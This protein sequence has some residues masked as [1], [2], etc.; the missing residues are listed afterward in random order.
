[1]PKTGVGRRR[2][3]YVPHGCSPRPPLRSCPAGWI[4]GPDQPALDGMLGTVLKAY[5]EYRAG[6]GIDWLG[7][8]GPTSP[9]CCTT[10]TTPGTSTAAGVSAAAQ[11]TPSHVT[12]PGTTRSWARCG[13]AALRAAEEI[14]TSTRRRRTKPPS[15]RPARVRRG[16]V[17][18]RG[19]VARLL[20]GDNPDYPWGDG[21][22]GADRAVVGA[23]ARPRP[24]AARRARAR[25][26]RRGG[27][28]QPPPRVPGRLHTSVPVFA[29][30][31]MVWCAWP[32]GAGAGAGP[33]Q[34]LDVE[35]LGG[36]GGRALPARG[37][38]SRGAR[39]AG[40]RV[41]TLRRA[42][43]QP[44]QRDRVRRPLRS[45]A[46]P[47]VVEALQAWQGLPTTG[48]PAPT[49]SAAR[50]PPCRSWRAPVGACGSQQGAELVMACTGGQLDLHRLTGRRRRRGGQASIDGTAVDDA[51]RRAAQASIPRWHKAHRRA[52]T[53]V[54]E[55]G[56]YGLI[57]DT[58][59]ALEVGDADG[60]G[61]VGAD[62]HAVGAG[63]DGDGGGDGVGGGADHRHRA[64]AVS[65]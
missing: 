1:M 32:G 44:V 18:R 13:L 10:S 41:G 3:G 65:W 26:P 37:L 43:A 52:D 7:S 9:A 60:V 46:Q 55:L 63:A 31:T 54:G 59:L 47:L 35:P 53:D 48:R 34:I 38:P 39:R 19:C 40:R 22:L 30:V 49:P 17:H 62:R 64:G 4:G 23:P 56:I 33:L 28:A 6:A 12:S 61:A 42:A 11:Q 16:A 2:Q 57:T 50:T 8:S 5:R 20:P 24:P 27:A 14:A 45:L 58:Q 21:C 51:V 15:A 36:P 25:R 29:S